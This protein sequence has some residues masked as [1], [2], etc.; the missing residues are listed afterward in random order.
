MINDSRIQPMLFISGIVLMVLGIV[1]LHMSCEEFEHVGPKYETNCI[2]ETMTDYVLHPIGK[3]VLITGLIL[4][5]L[6]LFWGIVIGK[7]NGD[8]EQ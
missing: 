8:V 2:T 6:S 5:L 7:E 3:Y 4:F 1:F